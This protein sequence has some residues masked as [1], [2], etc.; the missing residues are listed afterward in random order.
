MQLCTESITL[1]NARMD[2]NRMTV[3]KRTV[4]H[5]VSWF[6]SNQSNVQKDGLSAN[7]QTAIR[8]PEDAELSGKKYADA[9]SYAGAVDVSS[10]FTFNPGD[11]VVKGIAAE[12]NTSPARLHAAYSDVITITAATDNRRGRSPHFKVVGG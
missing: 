4:I 3:Y 9:K 1:Y 10:L 5:G 6:S 12:E 11:V 7:K 2:E 8:I